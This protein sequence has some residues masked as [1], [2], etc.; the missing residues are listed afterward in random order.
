MS[1]AYGFK[2]LEADI[3]SVLSRTGDFR[4]IVD[5]VRPFLQT[6]LQ[7]DELLPE[8][9]QQPLP[10]KYA[11]YLLYKPED[12]AFSVIAFV[13]GPGQVAPVHD[14]L[15]W[16]L[17]G[18]Y[19]GAVEEKRYRRVDHGEAAPRRYTLEEVGTVHATKGD[20]SFVYP[21]DYDIHGVSNPH[22][23]VA[24]TIHVYGADIGKQER[25]IHDPATGA[26]RDVVTK[27]DNDVP[28]YADV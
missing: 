25:H 21:P 6:L 7:S 22:S 20:I 18:I 27:H 5:E 10:H 4:T 14:H 28:I 15:V 26:L 1:T 24:V 17:V 3:R 13:W 11:Q 19:K 9:Y 23:E 16:G 8:R 12:E 2:E